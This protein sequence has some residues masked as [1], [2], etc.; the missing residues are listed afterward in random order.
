MHDALHRRDA[1][2]V[3]VRAPPRPRHAPA[4][5]PRQR[6]GQRQP[7]DEGPQAAAAAL[8]AAATSAHRPRR[9]AAARHARPP[10]RTRPAALRRVDEGAAAGLADRYLDARRAPVAVRHP[11][12]QP[13][14]AGDR[15][16]LRA[17]GATVV[18]ARVLGRGDLRRGAALSQGGP[19]GA[20]AAPAPGGAEHPVPDAAALIERGRLH[21]LQRQR[22]A[23]L[24]AAGGKERRRRV[25]GVRLA[26]L[27]RQ[28][29]GGDG[30]GHRQRRAVRGHAVLHR[31]HLRRQP[32]EVRSQVLRRAGEAARE[33]RRPHHR[34]QGHGRRVQAARGERAGQG[35]EGGGRPAAALPHPRHQRHRCGLGAGGGGCRLRRGR[36]RARRAQWLD[37]AAQPRRDRRGAQ[38]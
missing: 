5:V 30:C 38:G 4:Q 19:L 2:A 26:Q 11:H 10:A 3:P 35:A 1:G 25:P 24:R 33:G 20:P 34:H 31:R 9:A 37:L 13:R 15:A 6:G 32:A 36:W 17:A 28:H 16:A 29:A 23:L 8:A 18:L 7:R 12:A 27:G 22:R 14:H 21:Q